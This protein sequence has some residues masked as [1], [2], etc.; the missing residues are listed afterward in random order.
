MR[1]AMTGGCQCG[2][3][4][5]AATIEDGDEAYLCHCKMC[6]RA[7]G[8]AATAFVNLARDRLYWLV[9]PD[10]YRSSPIA[11]RPFCATCGTPLGFAFADGEGHI[12]LTLGSF[13]DPTRFKPV[14][15][16]ASESILPAW[17]DTS[18]LPGMR[19]DENA[20]VTQRWMDSLGRL[21]D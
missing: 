21:P 13:D 8:A 11:L 15:N 5:Y 12:D 9:E 18:H 3:I 14:R 16:Y 1:E 7:T 4:R 19:S 2:R 6:R 17:Q 20:G 10:W